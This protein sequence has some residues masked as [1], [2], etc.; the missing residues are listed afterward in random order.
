GAD[1]SAVAVAP[2]PYAYVANSSGASLSAYGMD[3]SSGALTPVAGSP[4]AIGASPN[5]LVVD[6]SGTHVYAAESQPNGVAGYSI[7]SASGALTAI[8]GSPF[9]ASYVVSAPVMDGE[10]KRLHV[11]NGTDVDCFWINSSA[12][13][14]SELGLSTTGGKAI[15]LA[16]DRT[17]NFL[18]VLDNVN[19]QVEV[20]SVAPTDGSLTLINGSPFALFSGAASQNLG[21][22]AIAVAH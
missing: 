18:Y 12:G 5:G 9:H 16:M 6:D 4:F 7:D 20:F 1:A 2:G 3:A 21:P 17:D 11:A 13:D 22:N 10:G 8:A 15:A 14:L 19:N